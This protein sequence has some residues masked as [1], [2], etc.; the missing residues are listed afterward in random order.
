M[1]TQT[2]VVTSQ[3][4]LVVVDPHFD[5]YHCLLEPARKRLVRLTL[6]TTGRNALRLLP[7]FADALWLLSPQL[8]DM[9]GLDL[10]GMLHSV[11][12]K[13]NVVVVDNLYDPR[14]E[15]RALELR[16]AQYVC[17][18]VQLAWLEA[19]WGAPLAVQGPSPL[20]EQLY[21]AEYSI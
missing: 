5:D 21:E 6:T 2:R 11:Q 15:Q 9:D 1:A 14:R 12:W 17:K 7:S 18:P 20:R 16:A 8:P 3:G 13:L 10:L 19:W 4:C